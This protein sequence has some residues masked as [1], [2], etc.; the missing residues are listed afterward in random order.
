MNRPWRLSI[1]SPEDLVADAL[2]ALRG[3]LNRDKLESIE[4]IIGELAERVTNMERETE[5]YL[6][7][8]T[9]RR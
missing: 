3:E 9:W 7:R 4:C 2:T 1:L 8:R 5:M 6:S